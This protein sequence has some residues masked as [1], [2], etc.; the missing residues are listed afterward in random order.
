MSVFISAY[1]IMMDERYFEN[2]TKFNPEHFSPKNKEKR[3]PG[4]DLGFGFGARKCIGNRLALLQWKTGIAFTVQKF[5]ILPTARTP[6][7][8]EL[9]PKSGNSQIKGGIWIRFEERA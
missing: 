1:G 5:K 3:V 8:L 9:D 6:Q 7:K 2:P 4:T